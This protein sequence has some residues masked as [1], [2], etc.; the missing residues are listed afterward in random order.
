M[1]EK[2]NTL[3]DKTKTKPVNQHFKKVKYE[4]I[5]EEFKMFLKVKFQEDVISALRQLENKN[6][7][8]RK[9]PNR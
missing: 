4:K 6:V 9:L 2:L 3:F 1:K 8:V 5:K 7:E